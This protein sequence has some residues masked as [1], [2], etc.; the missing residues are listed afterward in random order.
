MTLGKYNCWSRC[1]DFI[2]REIS[3]LT[4]I[5]IAHKKE[6]CSLRASSPACSAGGVGKGGGACIY[7]SGI[8]ISAS[9]KSMRNADW[10]R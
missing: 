2:V 4:L 10:R 9:K 5:S 7:V 3:S 1:C 8:S 6:N